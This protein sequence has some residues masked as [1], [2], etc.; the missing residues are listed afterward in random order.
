MAHR[1]PQLKRT[2]LP[3]WIEERTCKLNRL[4][5]LAHFLSYYHSGQWSRGYRY[6]SITLRRLREEW[7]IIHPLDFE[8]NAYENELLNHLEINYWDKV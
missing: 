3:W 2:E 5:A 8:L 7:G 6:L 4:L 1:L